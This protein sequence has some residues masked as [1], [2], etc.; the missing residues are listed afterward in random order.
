MTTSMAVFVAKLV[1]H[2]CSSS[3]GNGILRSPG[4]IH[5]SL[6]RLYI[7]SMFTVIDE[8]SLSINV[9]QYEI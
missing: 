2:T 6:L 9:L 4:R 8:I 5:K 7:E 1:C 3:R